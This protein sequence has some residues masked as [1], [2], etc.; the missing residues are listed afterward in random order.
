M[1]KR[2]LLA[3]VLAFAAGT[4]RAPAAPSIAGIGDVNVLAVR[5]VPTG[6]SG[7]G[8]APGSVTYVVARLE[9]TNATTH[10]FTP[11]ISR[12]FLTGAS[13]ARSD[14]YQGTDSGSSVFV[15]VSNSHRTLKQGDKRLYTVGFR[16]TDPV[17]AGTVSYE[18]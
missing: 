16:S 8:L 17:I 18:P 6:D 9:L 12:F 1:W 15:G 2:T 14:R 3:L 11:D 7:P 4:N 5:F 13:G 10:D